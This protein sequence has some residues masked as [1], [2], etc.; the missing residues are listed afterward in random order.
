MPGSSAA[1][2]TP[3]TASNEPTAESAVSQDS[4]CARAVATVSGGDKIFFFP[5]HLGELQPFDAG[6]DTEHKEQGN[7]REEDAFFHGR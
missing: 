6:K 3:C 4:L 2:V 1:T 5:C 7:E